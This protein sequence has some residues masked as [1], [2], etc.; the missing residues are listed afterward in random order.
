MFYAMATDDVS[1]GSA[2]AD[3]SQ[4]TIDYRSAGPVASDHPPVVFVHGLL[5]DARLW[6]PVAQRLAARGIRS[7]A[8]TLPLGSHR[9]PMK[10]EADLSPRG[11]AAIVRDFAAALDLR[12]VVLVGNDTGGAICQVILGDAA[13]GADAAG[14]GTGGAGETSRIGAAVLT[15]CDAFDTF[16]PAPLLPLFLALRYPGLVAGIAPTLASRAVRHG[17][18]AYG[19]LASGALDPELTRA[20]VRPLSD[21][22]IRRDVA[23]FAREVHPRV[24]LEAASRFGQFKGPVRILWGEK[25]RYFRVTLGRRLSEAFGNS[26]FATV[27]DGLTFLPLDHPGRVAD[28]ITAALA[29]SARIA[30]YRP[31]SI[32]IGTV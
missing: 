12:D 20:W 25:D 27:P 29:L 15:D 8:P 30:P 28:E 7:Y 14:G 32:L 11:I 13:G 9:H 17:P 6:D 1:I 21:P 31:V 23:K 19:M 4:G 24:L 18:L 2:T 3:L 5:V 22:A 26:A 16:P 10:A